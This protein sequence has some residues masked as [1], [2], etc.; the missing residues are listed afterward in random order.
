MNFSNAFVL[1]IAILTFSSTEGEER[2]PFSKYPEFKAS[3]HFTCENTM[4]RGE[5][6]CMKT[7]KHNSSRTSCFDS[8]MTECSCPAGKLVKKKFLF[9]DKLDPPTIFYKLRCIE[10]QHCNPGS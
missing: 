10:P 8:E 2:D 4:I 1:V 5:K 9:N 7:C 6:A 3:Y